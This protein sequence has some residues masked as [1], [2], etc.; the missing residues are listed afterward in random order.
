MIARIAT[1]LAVAATTATLA[2]TPVPARAEA[3]P[4]PTPAQRA[5]MDAMI[6][7][8]ILRNPEIILEAM[9]IL[10][11]RRDMAAAETD[12]TLASTHREALEN[13]GF[14]QVLG[15]PDGD[16]TVVEFFDYR[17]GYCKQAHEHVKE[18][19][20]SDGSIR[21]IAKEFPILGP[22]SVFAA[23]A[24][25]AASVQGVDLY[26]AFNSE[27]MNH[28][29]ALSENTVFAIAGDVGLDVDKLRVDVEDP[30]LAENIRTT[31]G[32][33]RALEITG[34]P[35]FVI[36]DTILRGFAPLETMRAMVDEARKNAG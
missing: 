8:Y 23:R 12:R 17:C 9:E 34:T 22:E 19:V 6:R 14:S 2:L 30:Q 33:A 36:G 16:V 35:G 1:A 27:L 26:D 18:L 21:Y 4:P 5:A 10:E 31:Y 28:T 7:D 13:D 15:N 24:A 29:G 25:M 3:L 20:E 11:Q 32:L